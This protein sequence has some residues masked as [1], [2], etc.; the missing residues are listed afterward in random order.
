MAASVLILRF[1]HGYYPSE[2]AKILRSSSRAVSLR[3][4]IARREA[5][6]SLSNPENLKF[7]NDRPVEI[8]PVN[9]ARTIDD[10]LRE[11]RQMIFQ[12]RRGE[13]LSR[14]QLQ[15]L[16]PKPGEVPR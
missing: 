5:K 8:F 3:L 14:E 2:I 12:S 10:L 6:T 13:C 15:K 11:L 16:Y 4:R 7:M 1:F 9:F